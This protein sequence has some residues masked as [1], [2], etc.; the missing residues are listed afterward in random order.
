MAVGMVWFLQ[1]V[2]QRLP[3]VPG[4]TGL[5]VEQ[6]TTRQLASSERTSE[7]PERSISKLEVLHNLILDSSITFAMSVC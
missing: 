4:Y 6:L 1:A 5:S 7:K 2:S 3:V